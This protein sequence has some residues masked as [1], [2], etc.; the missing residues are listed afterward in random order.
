MVDPAAVDFGGDRRQSIGQLEREVEALGEPGA[1]PLAD[2][3]A[4]DDGLDRVALGFGE[5]GGLVGDLDDLAV[6]PRPDQPRAA[7]GLEHLGVRP[8]PPLDKGCEDHQ[9]AAWGEGQHG[10]GHLLGR[11]AVDR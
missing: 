10:R 8:L 4:I 2:D 3:Q 11:L 5:L 6:H 7:D 9:P 1:D